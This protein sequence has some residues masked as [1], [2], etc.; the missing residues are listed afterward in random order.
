MRAMRPIMEEG[1]NKMQHSKGLFLFLTCLLV[2][3]IP[4]GASAKDLGTVLEIALGQLVASDLENRFGV[5]QDPELH[6]RVQNVALQL[7][8]LADRKGIDYKFRVLDSYEVNAYAVLGGSVYVN[9]GLLDALG[10]ADDELAFALAHEITHIKEKHGVKQALLG[11][12][13]SILLGKL[14]S[15]KT[16]D[17]AALIAPLPPDF[18]SPPRLL[19]K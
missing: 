1:V 13:A 18:Y 6:A 3:L 12:V 9:R 16:A 11:M 14:D 2:L 8:S 19:W 17:A 5:S 15:R 10:P 7:A 4:K